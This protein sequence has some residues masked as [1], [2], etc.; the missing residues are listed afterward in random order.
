MTYFTQRGS[1]LV[2]DRNDKFHLLEGSLSIK[3]AAKYIWENEDLKNYRISDEALNE[4]YGNI[5]V[6]HLGVILEPTRLR[7]LGN[8]EDGYFRENYDGE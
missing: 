1:L 5:E 6:P 7:D 8:K 3:E 2:K 4:Q